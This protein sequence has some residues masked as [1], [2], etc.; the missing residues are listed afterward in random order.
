[1]RFAGYLLFIMSLSITS[2]KSGQ[3]ENPNT[4][5]NALTSNVEAETLAPFEEAFTDSEQLDSFILRSRAVLTLTL[6]VCH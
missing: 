4:V 5:K 1:M 6:V 3:N 2:C